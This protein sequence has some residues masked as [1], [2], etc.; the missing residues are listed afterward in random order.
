MTPCQVERTAKWLMGRHQETYRYFTQVLHLDVYNE[1]V[2]A[3][4]VRLDQVTTTTG[5]SLG[6]HRAVI[7][8]ARR[9]L[10]RVE[11]EVIQN[12]GDD[13]L[14]TCPRSPSVDTIIDGVLLDSAMQ[15][16]HPLWRAAL[17]DLSGD[18]TNRMRSDR[19]KV[20]RDLERGIESA[21]FEARPL[22]KVAPH[23]AEQSVC[24]PELHPSWPV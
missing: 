12:D 17:V 16:L 13:P 22:A 3:G 5:L 23:G 19:T 14:F 9:R 20:R 21:G 4:L 15:A 8:I 24:D 2:C 7:D 18:P 10:L 6:M 11:E 1:L